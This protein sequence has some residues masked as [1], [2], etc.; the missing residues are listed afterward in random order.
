LFPLRQMLTCANYGIYVANCKLCG[1]QYVGHTSYN[2]SKRW[3]FHRS[4]WNTVKLFDDQVLVPLLQ[5][6]HEDKIEKKREISDRFVVM[7]VEQRGCD[8]LDIC[9]GKWLNKITASI[10]KH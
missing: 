3:N 2:F 10:N 9:E 5:H 7:L 4:Q 6:V 1:E 8:Y